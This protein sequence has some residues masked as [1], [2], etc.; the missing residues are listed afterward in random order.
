M[1]CG[2]PVVATA[3]G[4]FA[5]AVGEPSTPDEAGRIVPVE[6]IGAVAEAVRWALEDEVRWAELSGRAR[7]RVERLFSIER[8]AAEIT[9]I[10]ERLWSEQ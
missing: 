4:H 2:L 1:A 10:Y 7:A 6:D 3:T 5:E 9:A 8:E